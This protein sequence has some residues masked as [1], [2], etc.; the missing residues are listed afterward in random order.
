VDRGPLPS[1][2][3]WCIALRGPEGSPL[4]LG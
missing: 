3:I 1:A 2:I 4:L